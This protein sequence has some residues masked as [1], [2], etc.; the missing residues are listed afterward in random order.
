MLEAWPRRASCPLPAAHLNQGSPMTTNNSNNNNH[1]DG[2]DTLSWLQVN[3]LFCVCLR[4][5]VRLSVHW[6]VCC[7]CCCWCCCLSV[8]MFARASQRFCLK[9][10]ANISVTILFVLSRLHSTCQLA[11]GTWV[12]GFG[13]TP[14]AEPL[15]AARKNQSQTF[16]LKANTE[17]HLI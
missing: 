4:L 2:D 12:L 8:Y 15:K 10:S 1:D 3:Q 7:C 16:G 11:L 9:Q 6:F 17:S 14:L 5:I 13:Q